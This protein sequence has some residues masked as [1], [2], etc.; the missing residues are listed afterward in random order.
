MVFSFI[1]SIAGMG[2]L[3]LYQ[4][5]GTSNALFSLFVL[6]AKFGISSAFNLVYLG[7]N[8]LFPISI[9][10]TSYGICNFVA[11][12]FTIGA[13]FFAELKPI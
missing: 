13:P 10:A 6:G 8:L 9:K 2:G 12:L 11:R 5:N 4:T 3:M 7:N 1:I